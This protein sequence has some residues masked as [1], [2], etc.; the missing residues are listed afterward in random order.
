MKR[1]Y[2]EL[3]FC[4]SKGNRKDSNSMKDNRVLFS[5]LYFSTIIYGIYYLIDKS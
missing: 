3:F 1:K 2:R 4:K 5:Q